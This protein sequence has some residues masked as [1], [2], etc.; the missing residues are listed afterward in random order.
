MKSK[1]FLALSI[2]FCIFGSQA[3]AQA[4]PKRPIADKWA[5]IVGVDNYKDTPL[6][7]SNR[8]E[9]AKKFYTFLTKDAHFAPDHCMLMLDG[10][11]TREKVLSP[12]S[13]DF[14]PRYVN[15]NDMMI[16]YISTAISPS[17]A[18]VSGV[19][20]ALMND[21]KRENL[22]AT[23]ISL[24]AFTTGIRER[25]QVD[26]NNVVVIIDGQYSKAALSPPERGL[27]R[28]DNKKSEGGQLVICSGDLTKNGKFD[29]SVFTNQLISA[30]KSRGANT[31]LGEALKTFKNPSAHALES[32]LQSELILSAPAAA[33]R[34]IR[35]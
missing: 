18:D 25:M 24:S 6:N 22:Y 5:M 8:V 14:F 15:R 31:K 10:D 23:G 33:P 35:N 4:P 9:N 20:Y 1:L 21:S 7:T 30:L 12:L 27:Y 32:T 2:S 19:N 11:A 26:P 28:G 29:N 34:S 13:C 3:T 17:E 16:V